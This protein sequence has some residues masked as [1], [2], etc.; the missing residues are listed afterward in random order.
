[1]K[2]FNQSER[3]QAQLFSRLTWCN[4]FTEERQS[5]E[6]TLLGEDYRQPN[7]GS[8][9]S[10]SA[11]MSQLLPQLEGL[12]ETVQPRFRRAKP[13]AEDVRLYRDLIL[14]HL[15]HCM[16]EGI[17]NYI[18]EAHARGS[19]PGKPT[20]LYRQFCREA[21]RFQIE[22]IAGF[23][24]SK[25]HLFACFYQVVCAY[26]HIFD[27]LAGGS[28]AVNNLRARVWQSVFTVDMER[29]QRVLYN[30][31]G[32]VITLVCGASGT[33]KELVARAIGRS[34]FIPLDAQSGVFADDFVTAFYPLNLSALSPQLIESELFGHR[35]GA[36]TGALEDRR[37][38]FEAC[39]LYGTV[40]LDEIGETDLAV[41]VKLLRVLQT[42]QY[43]RLG[44]TRT[45]TFSGKVIA[46]TNRDLP[47]E[48][49]AGRFREDFYYRL[50]AD[51]V[52]T[53]PLK[54]ILDQ[55]PEELEV[56]VRHILTGLLGADEAQALVDTVVVYILQNLGNDYPWSGN[57]RELEQ[58]VRNI[59]IHGSYRP[60][61]EKI[62]KN[63]TGSTASIEA[64]AQQGL[65]IDA[66]LT[67]YIQAVY[68]QTQNYEHTANALG[69]DR[70]TVK[71]Y[72]LRTN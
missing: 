38:Y 26:F 50:C 49:E 33:G 44:D 52:E 58:C 13:N 6:R 45:M 3:Q 63:T 57:F 28:E 8:L 66:L 29:Y 47:R 60:G 42:R 31:M 4:P 36:F 11:N 61:T 40:F 21:D 17:L 2:L 15:Y 19:T 7:M 1:M 5:L 53:V 35:K 72:A 20:A 23:E 67:Q 27:G 54:L 10:I 70:R 25:P 64:L 30:R 12:L 59:V 51:Q 22:T 24:Y 16:I 32:D 68:A 46:A 55:N 39:G 41:Q 43:Q 37:G 62:R 69:I 9:R 14:F 48:M 56:L 34:R 71:K 65:S 18:R